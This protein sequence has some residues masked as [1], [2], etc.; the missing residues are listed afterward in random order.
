MD[1]KNNL[2]DLFH[3]TLNASTPFQAVEG[4]LSVSRDE[5]NICGQSFSLSERPVYVW[6]AGKAAVS[7]SNSV[8]QVLRQSIAG[9]LVTAP[10]ERLPSDS[11]ADHMIRASHPLPDD[12]SE[13]AGNRLANFI[14][15]IPDDALVLS[16][17]SGGTSSLVCYPAEGLSVD[18]ISS[19]FE[20]LSR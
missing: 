4:A 17:I 1:L 14:H 16:L 5:I 2:K 6:A 18:D 10:K 3:R 19:L 9:S 12:K 8:D 15:D 7:T 13:E 11:P 20:L